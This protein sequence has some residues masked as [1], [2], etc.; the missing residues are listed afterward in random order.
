MTARRCATTHRRILRRARTRARRGDR[1]RYQCRRLDKSTDYI[2]K[3]IALIV[4]ALAN[5]TALVSVHAS[6]D[7][8]VAQ[9]IKNHQAVIAQQ[10]GAS[11]APTPAPA[12]KPAVQPLDHG[13]RAQSTPWLNAQV[14][15]HA[16]Q[17]EQARLAAHDSSAHSSASN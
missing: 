12:S 14:R 6:Q 5:L 10:Q 9:A 17:A 4:F 15:E 11:A 3:K 16:A 7:T 8:S 13:P 1:R 2:V